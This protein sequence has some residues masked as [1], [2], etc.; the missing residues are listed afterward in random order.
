MSIPM[1][2]ATRY[3]KH[4][5]TYGGAVGLNTAITWPRRA[6]QTQIWESRPQK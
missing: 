1:D 6:I 2:W 5:T 4:A 3:H